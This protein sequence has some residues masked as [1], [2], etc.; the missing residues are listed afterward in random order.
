MHR[1][2]RTS[3]PNRSSFVTELL[4]R[5]DALL[6]FDVANVYANARNR[7]TDP[8]AVLDAL[9]LGCSAPPATCT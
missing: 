6:L 2:P 8:V 7:G 4:E 9:P 5:T 1:G 3:T